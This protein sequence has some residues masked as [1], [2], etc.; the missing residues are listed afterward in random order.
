MVKGKYRVIDGN[1]RICAIQNLFAYEERGVEITLM[2][3][4]NL[5]PKEEITIYEEFNIGVRQTI[6]DFLRLNWNNISI[7]RALQQKEV[8]ISPRWHKGNVALKVLTEPYIMGRY[9]EVSNRRFLTTKKYIHFLRK[10]NRK[11]ADRISTFYSSYV[12]EFGEPDK[13][14]TWWKNPTV[15]NALYF[16]SKSNMSAR[17]LQRT[18][19]KIHKKRWSIKNSSS[20][21]VMRVRTRMEPLFK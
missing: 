14:D 12:N 3:Y 21:E 19:K 18:L 5:T 16:Y 1:H 2:Y 10:L 7:I 6:A 15:K 11:D 8:Q 13:K 4:T 9:E 17:V 20:E